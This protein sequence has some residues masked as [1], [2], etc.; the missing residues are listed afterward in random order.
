ML[1]FPLPFPPAQNKQNINAYE[2]RLQADWIL[3]TD[4]EDL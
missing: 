3:K 4:D 1:F 2:K